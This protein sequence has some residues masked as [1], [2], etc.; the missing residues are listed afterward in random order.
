MAERKIEERLRLDALAGAC[1]FWSEATP[2]HCHR[3]LVCEYL[4]GKLGGRL[5]VRHP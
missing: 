1:L 3:L 5:R 2:D 4:N